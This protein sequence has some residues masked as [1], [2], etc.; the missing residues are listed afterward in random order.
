M[1]KTVTPPT[2]ERE[3]IVKKKNTVMSGLY[4]DVFCGHTFY[5]SETNTYPGGF[6]WEDDETDQEDDDDG[7]C[8]KCRERYEE[9]RTSNELS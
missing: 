5:A 4:F 6:H 2:G 3:H 7:I 9:W 1:P 8:H